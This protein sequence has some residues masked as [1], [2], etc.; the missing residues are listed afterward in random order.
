MRLVG[1]PRWFSR[2][3]QLGNLRGGGPDPSDIL[4][5]SA[6][7]AEDVVPRP[8]RHTAVDGHGPDRRMRKYEAQGPLVRAHQLRHD[9]REIMAIGA[10]AVQ[11]DDSPGRLAAG[12]DLNGFEQVM[13]S[14]A[15][16]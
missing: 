8:H 4:R 3:D 5:G 10:Q 6:V 12:F 13:T 1:I 16:G 9:R 15:G 14:C 11:P 7:E 2:R